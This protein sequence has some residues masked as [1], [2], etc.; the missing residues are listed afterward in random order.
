MK[1]VRDVVSAK[2]QDT[3]QD[4]ERDTV[5]N[6]DQDID[7]AR[8]QSKELPNDECKSQELANEPSIDQDMSTADE[9]TIIRNKSTGKIKKLVWVLAGVA[10]MIAIGAGICVGIMS[11]QMNKISQISYEDMLAYTLKDKNDAVITVGIIKNGKMTYT[12]YGKNAEIL[13]QHE[14]IYEIGSLTK[15]FTTSLLCKAVSEGKVSLEKPISAYLNLP[16]KD[17]Y[18]TLARLVTHTSGYKGYYLEGQMADNFFHKQQNDFYGIDLNTFEK[19]IGKINLKNK[20]YKFK[21]TNFGIAVV[22]DV[23][24]KVYGEDYNTLINTFIQKDLKLTDTRINDG[25][26]DLTGYWNWKQNDAYLP[27]G[28]LI[29]DISDVM[30][31]IQLHMTNKIPYL[32]MSHEVLA[33]VN[34]TSKQYA[35]MGIRM[36]SVGMGWI[37]DN[38]N[39]I[40]WHNGGTSNFNCYAGFNE[41]K[42]IGVVVLSNLSPNDR[43]PATVIGV[44][45]LTTLLEE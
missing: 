20:D 31:Y 16:E 15:T 3:E 28:S 39:H 2:N 26:G 29:S 11:E 18:P 37:I 25:S 14:Y 44:K 45:L 7:Q 4:I 32:S 40:V 6:I 35:A 1:R 8:E 17:Y 30:N 22:G 41:D 10:V 38:E 21:Y 19:R 42:Q 12:V 23:L 9:P 36:D 33:Q 5:Q 24:A 43:I 27:A 34:A 13:P